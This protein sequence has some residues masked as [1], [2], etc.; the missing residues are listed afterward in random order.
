MRAFSLVLLLLLTIG[1]PGALPQSKGAEGERRKLLLLTQGS[2]PLSNEAQYFKLFLLPLLGDPKMCDPKTF[3]AITVGESLLFR[4]DKDGALAKMSIEAGLALLLLLI[5]DAALA[6]MS[7][8]D[9]RL[10]L[11]ALGALACSIDVRW[12]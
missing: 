11:L 3:E 9:L 10:L 2:L 8:E 6:M 5:E 4:K 12:L 7:I 1:A